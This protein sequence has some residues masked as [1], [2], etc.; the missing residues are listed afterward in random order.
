[1]PPR[2]TV[3][4]FL[5]KA[6][7]AKAWPHRHDLGLVS[8]KVNTTKAPSTAPRRYVKAVAEEAA[9]REAL[10]IFTVMD[11]GVNETLAKANW[12]IDSLGNQEVKLQIAVALSFYHILVE[13]RNNPHFIKIILVL[14]E[15]GVEYVDLWAG[16]LG[17]LEKKFGAPRSGISSRKQVVSK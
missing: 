3:Y 8:Q 16:L 14:E 2:T 9:D 10:V 6:E 7:D 12:Q 5:S 17:S 11:R 1:M 4:R 15:K 13:N